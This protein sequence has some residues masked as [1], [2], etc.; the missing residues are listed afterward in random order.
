MK[1]AAAHVPGSPGWDLEPAGLRKTFIS[2]TAIYPLWHLAAPAGATDPWLAWWLVAASFLAVG[3]VSLRVA[4]VERNLLTCFH[5]CAWLITLHMFLLAFLNDMYPFYAVG[6]VMAVLS[7]LFFIRTIPNL[8]AYSGFVFALGAVLFALAPDGRKL[9]YW[10]G[11][12]PVSAG[13]WLR[14]A[15]QRSRERV[16][17]E[18]QQLLE[19][20]VAE[21]TA[22]L[23]QA[24]R[25]LE[26]EIKERERVE[27]DLRFSQQLEALGRL[28][29][30]VAHDFNNLLTTIGVYAELLIGSLPE[31]DPIRK[32]AAQIQKASRQASALTQQLL[33]FAHRREVE[34]KVIDV[35]ETIEQAKSM[36][37][38]LLGEDTELVCRL[39]ATP[40]P[41]RANPDELEQVLINLAL[42]ARDAMPEGGVFTIET[43]VLRREE[44]GPSELFA[45]KA[46]EYVLLA[47][48]DT[49]VGMDRETRELVFEPFFTRKDVGE[50]TGLGLSMVYGVVTHAGGRIRVLSE[51]GRGARFELLWPLDRRAPAELAVPEIGRLAPG[52]GA[53]ILL[54]EDESGLR[55]ALQRVLRDSG[56]GVVG[57][58]NAEVA[59][60]IAAKDEPFDLVVTDVVMP[61]M[62]GLELIEALRTTRPDT[63]ILLVS[64]YLNHP[65]LRDQ[66]LPLGVSLLRKPFASS[67]LTGKVREVLDAAPP[68]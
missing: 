47:V 27:A 57:A 16:A 6:S 18:Q 19:R 68:A 3:L 15:I 14:L 53:R 36:L 41:I 30:G 55:S 56:Y 34:R 21:R 33:A 45:A 31:G 38:H 54:V 42:N 25:R 39:A 11:I 43:R 5:L 22:E 59:L 62:S 26:A 9:A 4:F 29:G 61:R 32:D 65:S 49:G 24:N 37:E 1:T 44:L 23:S 52:R 12:L 66:G 64:G 51:P 35:R 50:G 20:R 46:A 10:G 28:A 58:E 8:V 40:Q 13:C 60:E 2:T 7:T 67:D 17:A 63:R 48:T